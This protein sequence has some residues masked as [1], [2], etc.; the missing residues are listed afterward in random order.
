MSKE[1]DQRLRETFE[2]HRSALHDKKLVDDA[3]DADNH[4]FM[5]HY[6]AHRNDVIAPTLQRLKTIVGEYGHNM[7]IECAPGTENPQTAERAPIQATLLL[8]GYDLTYKNASPQLRFSANGASRTIAVYASDSVPHKDGV[9]GQ[10]AALTVEEL[11]AE[12]IEEIFLGIV[13]RAFAH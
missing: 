9:S 12:K 10:Q 3:V 11:S 8:E 7:L 2:R 1:T 13:Q 5:R 4:Q 6:V